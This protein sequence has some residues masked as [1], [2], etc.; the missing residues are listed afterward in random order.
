V[1]TCHLSRRALRHLAVAPVALLGLFA[2]GA[3]CTQP[4]PADTGAPGPATT[5]V[6]A[7]TGLT[8]RASFT[9]T[10]SGAV[11]DAVDVT[12]TVTVAAPN[13]T[14]R[15]SRFTGTGQSLGVY[16]RSGDVRIEDCELRGD[17]TAAAVGFGSW[18]MVRSEISGVTSDGVK[19]GSNTTMEGNWLHDFVTAANAHNDGGQIETGATDV[20]IR[21]NTITMTTSQNAALFLAPSLGPSSDGPVLV[22]DNVLGGGNFSLNV[23]DGDH[24][25][26]VIGNITVRNNRFLRT[27]RY[28]AANVNVPV[29]AVGNVWD[30][31]GSAVTI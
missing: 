22:E 11:V 3:G 30:D 16:V 17:Y 12:G 14:I 7:G 5:G 27:A 19:I 23:L 6:P 4:P 24:G 2:L 15:R 1:S 8:P 13:V 21:R 25:R 29:T 31:T 10:T 9:V 28:G 20:V 18:T 26:Y